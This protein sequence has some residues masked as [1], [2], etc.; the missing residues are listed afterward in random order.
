MK[1]E[2]RKKFLKMYK[3]LPAFSKLEIVAVV[4]GEPL[5]YNDIYITLRNWERVD[6]GLKHM[7]EMKIL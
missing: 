6:E 4:D 1:E 2:R 3:N 7:E 5:T